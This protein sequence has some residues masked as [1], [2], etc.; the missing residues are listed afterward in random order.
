MAEHT[1]SPQRFGTTRFFANQTF[2]FQT[3]RVLNDIAANG[4]DLNE[5]LLTIG[6]IEEGNT[7]C[8]YQKF[9]ELAERTQARIP[10]CMDRLSTAYAWL[11]AHNYWRTAE[12]LLTPQDPR[13][14][15]AW[16]NQIAAF[17]QGLTVAGVP[18]TRLSV[19]YEGASLRAIVY[20]GPEGWEKRPLIVCC[21]GYDSTLEELYF[22]LV[23]AAYD[24][25][26]GVLTYEGPGQGAAL[27]VHGLTFTPA[28]EKP[29]RA[30]LD[31]FEQT[32]F[33]AA[34]TILVG[35]SMGG[36]LAPRA[37]AFE[38]RLDGVVAYDVFFDMG[39]VAQ[40][41][42]QSAQTAE[43]RNNPDITW[44]IDNAFWTLG[45]NTLDAVITAL[46]Q[47]S[48]APVAAAITC[49]VLTLVGEKDHFIPASQAQDF[50]AA[51]THARSCETVYYDRPSGG[52]EHCQLGAQT[53]WHATFFD[54]MARKFSS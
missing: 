5:V 28:W 17:D 9:A 30:V 48:L 29:T 32:Y 45:V 4:A 49:D 39:S 38:P 19:P 44:A 2:H 41:Y 35:M 51:C 36:Y 21:G 10:G 23:K 7:D 42:A 22:V 1:P 43:A 50:E 6:S 26:Y 27:R 20:S 12:F 46:Q 33:T 13:R 15:T 40:R 16:A 3:L 54:W 47:Y 34:K 25:G 14:L 11:R 18:Y 53:L 8:W 37:A 31:M 24:R 52:A